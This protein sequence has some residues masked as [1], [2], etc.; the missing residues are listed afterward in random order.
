LDSVTQNRTNISPDEI[1]W[2]AI[3]SLI[4]ITGYGG[5][6]DNEFDK[7]LLECFVNCLFTPAAYDIGHTLVDIKGID[8]LIVPK[9]STIKHFMNW[10]NKLPERQPPV[11][12][13]LPKNA[14]KVLYT[15]KG[16]YK[17]ILVVK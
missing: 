15:N 12:L 11:W 8:N 13:G 17:S 16:I 1:P 9:G 3:R 4:T 6:I 14:E 10:V 7:R 5:H 2:E